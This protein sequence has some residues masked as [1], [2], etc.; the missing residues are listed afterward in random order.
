MNESHNKKVITSGN[1]FCGNLFHH[2]TLQAPAL[3]PQIAEAD[4]N[5]VCK[6]L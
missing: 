1:A 6:D 3:L 2:F 4:I 5:K